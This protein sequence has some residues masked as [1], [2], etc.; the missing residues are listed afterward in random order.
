MSFLGKKK[1][2]R[3]EKKSSKRGCLAA[4]SLTSIAQKNREKKKKI[5]CLYNYY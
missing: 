5:S 1:R 3:E 4:R 2:E